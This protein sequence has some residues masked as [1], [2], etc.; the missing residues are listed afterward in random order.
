MLAGLPSPMLFL[1]LG[2]GNCEVPVRLFPEA[3]LYNARDSGA[4]AVP[5][6]SWKCCHAISASK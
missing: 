4:G 2:Q 6:L 1:D 3:E 5:S